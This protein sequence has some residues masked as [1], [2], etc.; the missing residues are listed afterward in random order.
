MRRESREKRSR[1]MRG[2]LQFAGGSGMRAFKKT[3][4]MVELVK[5]ELEVQARG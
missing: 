1:R 5:A 2:P 4:R 3:A